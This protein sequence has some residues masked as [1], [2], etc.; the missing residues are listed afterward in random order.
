[1]GEDGF[2]NIDSYHQYS[3]SQNLP[4]H[5]QYGR[6]RWHEFMRKGTQL[7]TIRLGPQMLWVDKSRCG[8]NSQ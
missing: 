3:A 6:D 7:G 8:K 1:M 5:I 4:I 2:K